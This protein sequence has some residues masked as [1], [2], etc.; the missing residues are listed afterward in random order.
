MF[1]LLTVLGLLDSAFLPAY[2]SLI[3][4]NGLVTYGLDIFCVSVPVLD[5]GGLSKGNKICDPYLLG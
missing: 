3:Q 2:L 5:S 4:I 1:F